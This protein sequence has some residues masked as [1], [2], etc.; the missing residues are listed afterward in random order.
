VWTTPLRALSSPSLI[1][2]CQPSISPLWLSPLPPEFTSLTS[3][4]PYTAS[5]PSTPHAALRHRVLVPALAAQTLR[6]LFDRG[7]GIKEGALS[8]L[9]LLFPGA[10]G[11]AHL[12]LDWFLALPFPSLSSRHS[13]SATPLSV[14]GL[15]MTSLCSCLFALF[16]VWI[17]G[18]GGGRVADVPVGA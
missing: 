5:P 16:L 9:P 12:S 18:D 13:T 7:G 4:F 10:F 11:A 17:R 8:S 14:F 15:G 1:R 3:L 6:A 2:R